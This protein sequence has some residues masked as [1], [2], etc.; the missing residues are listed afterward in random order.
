MLLGLAIGTVTASV[1]LAQDARHD[2]PPTDTAVGTGAERLGGQPLTGP[3]RAPTVVGQSPLMPTA[4]EPRDV[5]RH[6][7]RQ[8]GNDDEK[9]QGSD[10][11]PQGQTGK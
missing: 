9:T 11:K 2:A 3:P 8:P 7:K 6:Q 5:E 4:P 10:L 1:A